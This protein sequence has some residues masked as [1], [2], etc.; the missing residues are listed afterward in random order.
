[1]QRVQQGATATITFVKYTDANIAETGYFSGKTLD[2]VVVQE[3]DDTK[4]VYKASANITISNDGSAMSFTLAPDDT[5]IIS[6]Y[7][8]VEVR[9]TTAS[10]PVTIFQAIRA[11]DFLDN[12][13]HTIIAQ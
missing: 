9:D 8:N 6:G 7:A 1:M 5:V 10:Q 11:I 12:K 13:I 3:N 2:A 4:C